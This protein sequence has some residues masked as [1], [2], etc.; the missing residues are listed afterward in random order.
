MG[1]ERKARILKSEYLLL[2]ASERLRDYDKYEREEG[3]QREIDMDMEKEAVGPLSVFPYPFLA[4]IGPVRPV[5]ED[6]MKKAILAVSFGTSHLDTM[7]KTIGAIEKEL[8]GAF[9][10]RALYRAFTSG[11]IIR[12]LKL[13][14]HL[15]IDSVEEAV[16]RMREDGIEDV[17]IQPTHIIHGFEY[18]KM[19]EQIEPYRTGFQTVRIGEPLLATMEDYEEAVRQ[20]MEEAGLEQEETL[21]LMG[22]GT[23]HHTNAAYPALDY[24]FWAKGYPNVVV[25][26]VEGFPEMDEVLKKLKE[27]KAKKILLM[28][29]MIVAGDHAK[30][31]MAGEEADSWKSILEQ[32]G[33]EV[34]PVLKGLGEIPGIRKMFVRHAREAKEYPKG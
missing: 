9:P 11:M 27:R 3:S 22:H 13:D 8:S 34:R 32:A 26:T 10:D 1:R 29:F 28:P 12:K 2:N 15:E 23:E 31:D 33:Y 6:N 30:N 24:T 14:L 7:E 21:V 17:L 18:E 19:M 16:K 4:S 20:I 5:R 25:G